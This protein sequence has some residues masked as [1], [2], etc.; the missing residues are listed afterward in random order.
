MKAKVTIELDYTLDE[1]SS[2]LNREVA[3]EDFYEEV[4]AYVATDL[5]SYMNG[6]AL[7]EWASIE[8]TN[9]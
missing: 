4:M 3:P 7:D 1:L 6:Y 8:V 9:A 2:L 5:R